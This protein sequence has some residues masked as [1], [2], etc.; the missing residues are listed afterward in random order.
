M[1]YPIYKTSDGIPY[2]CDKPCE[3]AEQIGGADN[4]IPHDIW[5]VRMDSLLDFDICI[6]KCQ[7]DVILTS[8]CYIE[9]VNPGSFMIQICDD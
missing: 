9:T 2:N 5:V 1:Y 4:G 8:N 7:Y 3:G 6:G